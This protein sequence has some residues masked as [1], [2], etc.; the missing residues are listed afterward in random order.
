MC[1]FMW[2]WKEN[3]L[4]FVV[5]LDPSIYLH[6]F[7]QAGPEVQHIENAHFVGDHIVRIYR[8][9]QPKIK[10]FHF[11]CSR[12]VLSSW[13]YY[14]IH[15]ANNHRCVATTHTHLYLY[16]HIIAKFIEEKKKSI[17]I[18]GTQAETGIA[19]LTSTARHTIETKSTKRW[20][21]TMWASVLFLCCG[22]C[23]LPL[24][25]HFADKIE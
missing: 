17:D 6:K 19:R 21:C 24:T 5:A 25:R 14:Y 10:C 20:V 9:Y 15:A 12:S 8:K 3:R 18:A 16:I 11:T 2:K 13:S 22:R 23:R 4:T 7:L 1:A